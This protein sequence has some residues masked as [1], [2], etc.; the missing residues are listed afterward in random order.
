MCMEQFIDYIALI[1]NFLL[2]FALVAFMGR[3]TKIMREQ[4]GI[5]DAQNK[6]IRETDESDKAMTMVTRYTDLSDAR[7]KFWDCVRTLYSRFEREKNQRKPGT[8]PENV[9]S[10]IEDRQKG[11]FPPDFCP[12]SETNLLQFVKDNE[13]KWKR[14]GILIWEFAEYINIANP[15][16]NIPHEKALKKHRHDLAYFWHLWYRIL[17]VRIREYLEPDSKELLM[18]T[19]LEF[20]LVKQTQ[21]DGRAGKKWL[22]KLAKAESEPQP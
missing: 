9:Y 6:V 8:A 5:M 19:W 15:R 22:F 14:D 20:A 18:L 11:G 2:T 4:K 12:D 1:A 16:S 21:D 10:L 7:E 17:R 3:Q 13:C